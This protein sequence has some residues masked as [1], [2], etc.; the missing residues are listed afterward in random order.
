MWSMYS[1]VDLIRKW[2]W[3]TKRSYSQSNHGGSTCRYVESL[4]QCGLVTQYGDIE[5]GQHWLR[6]WW[7]QAITR[8][9]V[10]VRCDEICLRAIWQ[11]I[12]QPPITKISLKVS[13][14]KYHSNLPGANEFIY[15]NREWTLPL[16]NLVWSES[17]MGFHSSSLYDADIAWRE[18]CEMCE[19]AS[20]K[21]IKMW[22]WRRIYASTSWASLCRVM[23]WRL[24]RAE[25]L[26]K[27]VVLG[28]WSFGKIAFKSYPNAKCFFKKSY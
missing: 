16:L 22:G 4:T 28:N 11:E 27:L 6:H 7:H 14:W 10:D 20:S 5:L 12:A 15:F 19:N 26:H 8:T 3:S 9:I 1:S 24:F 23:L 17:I 2:V 25:L 18:M 21:W 13:Y